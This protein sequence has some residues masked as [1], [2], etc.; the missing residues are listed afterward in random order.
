MSVYNEM[1]K[2]I[3]N[4]LLLLIVSDD[5]RSMSAGSSSFLSPLYHPS[6][7]SVI[8]T[9]IDKHDESSDNTHRCWEQHH[10]WKYL[11]LSSQKWNHDV[12]QLS[13]TAASSTWKE[14]QYQHNKDRYVIML[15]W[16]LWDYSVYSWEKL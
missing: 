1:I 6:T 8:C 13:V 4:E 16:W 9:C 2:N 11:Y 7:H 3:Y 14:G 15:M 10:Q 12:Y 5:I